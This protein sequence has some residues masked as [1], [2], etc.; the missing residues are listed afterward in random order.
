MPATCRKA[1][2]PYHSTMPSAKR[3]L[4]PNQ[5]AINEAWIACRLNSVPIRTELDGDLNSIALMDAASCYILAAEL[6]PA[7][8]AEPSRALFRRMLKEGESHKQQLPRTLFIASED[9]ADQMTLEAS[10]QGIDVMRVP[11]TELLNFI[12]EARR[13]FAERFE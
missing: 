6:Y 2:A 5:F 11:E 7:T 9:L 12:G 1:A 3:I 8:E 13:A 4:H 10:Q